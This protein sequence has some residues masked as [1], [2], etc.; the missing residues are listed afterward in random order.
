MNLFMPS[1]NLSVEK[2]TSN[3]PDDGRFH[4]VKDGQ[5]VASYKLFAPAEK[6]Y[7]QLINEAGGATKTARVPMSA[8]ERRA[9]IIHEDIQ[10]NLDLF[11][12]YWGNAGT[13]HQGHKHRG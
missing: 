6:R 10:K 5:I 9:L 12:A 4:V 1:L 2:G 7:R 3:V 11:D 13:K 8:E